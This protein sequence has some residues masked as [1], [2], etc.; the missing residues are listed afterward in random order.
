M[1]AQSEA[2]FI[3][4]LEKY[5]VA[6]ATNPD[7]TPVWLMSAANAHVGACKPLAEIT[8]AYRLANSSA[9]SDPAHVQEL[10]Q[11]LSA[12]RTASAIVEGNLPFR[13]PT[14]TTE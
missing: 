2:A 6:Y 14:V 9:S 11:E 5:R 10:A 1:S 3:D 12:L 4:A 13:P 7:T 8:E